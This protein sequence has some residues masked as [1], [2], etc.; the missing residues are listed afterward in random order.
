MVYCTYL[1]GSVKSVK[2]ATI[3]DVAAHAGV[4][5]TTVS[6]VLNGRHN[7]E[8]IPEETCRRVQE[9]ARELGYH[10][11]A[12]AR[13]LTRRRTDSIGMVLQWAEW[14]SVWPGFL[15]EMMRGVTE[16]SFRERLDLVLHTREAPGG[17]DI[18][19][20]AAALMDGRVDGVLLMRND[21]D[22]LPDLLRERGLPFVLMFCRSSHPEDPVVEADNVAGGRVATEHLIGLG[23]RRILHVAGGEESSSGRERKAG[24]LVALAD[25][26]LEVN[27]DGVLPAWEFGPAVQWEPIEAQLSLPPGERPTAVFAWYDGAARRVLEIA[28]AQGLRVPEDLSVIG[29]DS[30]PICLEMDPPLTS[31]RQPV[32]EM[33]AYATSLLAHRLRGGSEPEPPRPDF[34][35]VIDIR[36]STGPFWSE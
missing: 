28:K 12:L 17:A 4:S 24:Y 10:P 32:R 29:Y 22:L 19:A 14:F 36:R 26:G 25:A 11:N 16:S 18:R 30:T 27:P 35:P 13:G 33:A 21:G 31:V 34:A 23:H 5:R 3:R 8:H 2:P 7:E 6:Y 9:S 20:E 1:T 15:S